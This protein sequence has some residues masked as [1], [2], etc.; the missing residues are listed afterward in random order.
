MIRLEKCSYESIYDLYQSG[1]SFFPLIAAVL[2]NEQDGVVYVDNPNSPS[3]AYVEHVF[4]FAQVFGNI[5]ADFEQNLARYLL[6]DKCFNPSKI[7][8]YTPYLLSFLT[9]PEHESLR[10]YRQRFTINTE[11]VSCKQ[12][13]ALSMEKDI[14]LT[15]VDASD[16]ELIDDKFGVVSRFWRTPADFILKSNAVVVF[17]KGE[18]A[19]LCYAAAEANHFVEIDVLTLPEFRNLGLAKFAVVN[20]VNQC[21]GLSLH[22]LWDCF[23]NN[24]GSMMLC[25][26]VGFT[27]PKAPYPFFTI[28]K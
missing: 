27:A 11:T 20:F 6:I 16:I 18:I 10:S 26:S 17:Y 24:L 15:G 4:G 3:Q 25:K 9:L 19:S 13:T 12:E 7:R 23:T 14:T 22:P 21:F 5:T 28:N 1:G 2:L 8:L